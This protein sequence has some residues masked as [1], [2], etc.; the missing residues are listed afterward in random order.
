MKQYLLFERTDDNVEHPQRGSNGSYGCPVEDAHHHVDI[1][2][3][4]VLQS[5]VLVLVTSVT[6]KHPVILRNILWYKQ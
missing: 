6:A 3:G 2:Q 4:P 1:C 5:I